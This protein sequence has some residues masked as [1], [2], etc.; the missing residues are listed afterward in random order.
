MLYRQLSK[1][2]VFTPFKNDLLRCDSYFN[3]NCEKIQ[4]WIDLS[5]NLPIRMKLLSYSFHHEFNFFQEVGPNLQHH[6]ILSS[7]D[8]YFKS[9][10]VVFKI[11][12]DPFMKEL[13]IPDVKS[14]LIDR[15]YLN[16]EKHL[17]YH[18]GKS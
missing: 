12:Y 13:T 8:A 5:L 6:N 18:T 2:L 14:I 1:N 7:V 3:S 11:L 4:Q 15:M 10:P 17:V 16:M 9:W